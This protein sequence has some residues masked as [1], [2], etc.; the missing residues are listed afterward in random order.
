MPLNFNSD[1]SR[2]LHKVDHSIL[3]DKLDYR[4][5]GSQMNLFKTY[6]A[7][8]T[9]KVN[10]Q[11]GVSNFVKTDHAVFQGSV[12]GPVLFIIYVNDMMFSVLNMIRSTL[13]DM[14]TI[15]R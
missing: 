1:P 11:Y 15:Y 14:L 3:V 2:A 8:R 9:A 4:I 5:G 12:L 10:W 6:F 13:L 7:N